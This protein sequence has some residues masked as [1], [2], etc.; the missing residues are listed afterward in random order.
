MSSS[1]AQSGVSTLEQ[2][3]RMFGDT[4]HLHRSSNNATKQ[5]EAL[6]SP[7]PSFSPLPRQMT[8]PSSFCRFGERS[9][10]TT[11]LHRRRLLQSL[12]P[13]CPTKRPGF[14]SLKALIS[15]AL[16][17]GWTLAVLHTNRVSTRLL[18][19]SGRVSGL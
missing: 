11:S 16:S 2:P 12:L 19:S 13:P 15:A 7:S 6:V 17:W 18:V 10:L 9:A 14:P 8:S 5:V 3:S 4:L 1:G